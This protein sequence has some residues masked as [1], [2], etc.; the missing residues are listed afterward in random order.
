M[1]LSIESA[2][3]LKTR[4]TV[5]GTDTSCGRNDAFS[6][7]KLPAGWRDSLDA[8][9]GMS[10]VA[11]E[12]YLFERYLPE[13]ERRPPS[14]MEAYY[15]VKGLIPRRVRHRLNSLAIRARRRQ[16]FPNWPCESALTEFWR[17]WMRQALE[18]MQ[19]SD[20]WH[21]GF[22]PGG[23]NCSIVLTHDVDSPL[24]FSQ[25]ERMAEVEEKLGFRSAWNLPLAQYPIDFGVVERLRTR[26][27]EFGAHGLS[28]DGKLF[29]SRKDFLALT[30]R[31]ERL[32]RE[33][34]M[35]GFRAPSTLRRAEWI[36][37]M[38]FD[39][40]SSFSD[41]D[42]YEPQAGG[43]CSIFPFYLGE[44]LEMPYTLAQDHTLIHV[45]HRSPLAVW[46]LKVQWIASL[47]GMILVLTHPDYSGA[48]A[49]LGHYEDLLKH[50]REIES[51]WHAQP[52]E[53]AAWWRRRSA[54]T[55]TVDNDVPVIEGADSAGAT[56]RR[57]SSEPLFR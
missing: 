2:T 17:D 42:P 44:M 13:N 28:H 27:F 14:A 53:I 30:P 57:I 24:G 6:F 7:W 54:M 50:L 49:N 32:A 1:A 12:R 5:I 38:D 39:F 16:K 43:T 26:G 31:L 48:G 37:T 18:I 41:T 22:W 52:S 23:V 8:L 55:L 25:M 20:G 11:A 34:N 9:N 21:I 15:R 10:A 36:A 29:R 4:P 40:D 33:H 45:L 35:R 3:G 56:A 47:G 51:A 46:M 19:V